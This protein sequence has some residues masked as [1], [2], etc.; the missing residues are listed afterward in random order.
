MPNCVR[1]RLASIPFPVLPWRRAAGHALAGCPRVGDDKRQTGDQERSLTRAVGLGQP[2]APR[3]RPLHAPAR[4]DD[5]PR[6]YSR[7]R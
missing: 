2:C 4:A 3:M 1:S 7:V 6:V 5:R